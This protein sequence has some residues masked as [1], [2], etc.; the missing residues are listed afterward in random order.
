MKNMRFIFILLTYLAV[1]RYRTF[2]VEQFEAEESKMKH[3]VK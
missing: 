2:Y 1:S 3:K